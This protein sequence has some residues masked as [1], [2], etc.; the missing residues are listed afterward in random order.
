MIK[1]FIDIGS[2]SG[3]WQ[4][5][6][7][8]Q[9]RGVKAYKWDNSVSSSDRFLPNQIWICL[10]H[11]WKSCDLAHL[12]CGTCKK[13]WSIHLNKFGADFVNELSLNYISI[14]S[15]RFIWFS[16]SLLQTR[17]PFKVFAVFFWGLF[18]A[19]ELG[20]NPNIIIDRLNSFGPLEC[21]KDNRRC[22]MKRA[23]KS[24]LQF[25]QIVWPMKSLDSK[26]TRV[27]A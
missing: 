23:N 6:S 11:S 27:L 24:K 12:E 21:A 18:Q 16:T 26:H 13:F 3:L 14:I 4:L 25:Y 7:F 19:R 1:Q 2:I 20:G 5:D 15:V 8:Y 10:I 9:E 22:T 17:V